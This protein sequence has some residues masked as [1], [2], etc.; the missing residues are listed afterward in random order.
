VEM[1]SGSFEL[2]N[3][4]RTWAPRRPHLGVRNERRVASEESSCM[5]LTDG[6]TLSRW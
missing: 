5:L 2:Q 1:F 6:A 3:I 4:N